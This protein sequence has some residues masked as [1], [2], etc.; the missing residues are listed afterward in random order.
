M[1]L[2][3][4][5]VVALAACLLPFTDI[6]SQ[7]DST[8]VRLD[9]VVVTVTRTTGRSV[10]GSPFAVSIVQPD[11]ARPGQRHAAIDESL[12]LIPGLTAINRNNPSQDARIS[13]RGF[14]A[15]SAFGVRGVRVIRDGMPLT[16]PDGQTPID[17]LSMESVGRIEIMRGAASALYGNASGGVIDIRT[18]AP[19]SSP[20]SA[21][22]KQWGG[23]HRSFRTVVGASG[24]V[25]HGYYVADV[26]RTQSDGERDHS[27]QRS[28]TGFLR[29]G[30]S[31]AGTSYAVTAMA[32]DNPLAQNP[33][34]LTIEEMEADR[35]IA[36]PPSVRRKA[37]KAVKQLQVGLSA[38]RPIGNGDI[39][40]SGF[41]GARS[42]D[43]PLTFAVVEV[44]RHTYGAA[45][46]FRQSADAVG[47]RHN[48]VAGV[49]L[50]WQNDL[51]RNYAACADTVVVLTP[52]AT[53]PDPPNERGIVTL[54]QRELVSSAGVYVSDEVDVGERVSLTAGVRGDKIRFTVRDR[55]V[56]SSNPDDSGRRTLQS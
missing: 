26:A 25:G 53:C 27:R 33:G 17:Y 42:L 56:T 6:Q 7:Q 36:D 8:P 12:A 34:A 43:N 30:L 1:P 24:T 5:L 44:G 15:R 39:S 50:Q 14:G 47:L 54:D 2:E 32:L 31:L 48:L 35:S 37:R 40:I 38:E 10:L 22:A 55:L 49:D 9:T 52:T 4:C 46:T 21:D 19:A 11:S 41:G 23:S 20:F 28:T 16:L 18:A 45:T 29:S 3:R 13:I 51:R